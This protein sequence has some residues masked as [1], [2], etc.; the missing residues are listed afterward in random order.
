VYIETFSLHVSSNLY[1]AKEANGVPF[2]SCLLPLARVQVVDPYYRMGHSPDGLIYIVY[3]ETIESFLRFYLSDSKAFL[4]RCYRE[5]LYR[6]FYL[7]IRIQ[8]FYN[9]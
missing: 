4:R 6:H 3:I 8:L 1:L 5:F 9:R 2:K 7:L